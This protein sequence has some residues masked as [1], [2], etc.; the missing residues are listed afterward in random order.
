ME[1]LDA[2]LFPPPA[3]VRRTAGSLALGFAVRLEG[4]A[5]PR[6]AR[7]TLERALAVCGIRLGEGSARVRAVLDPSVPGGPEASRLRVDAAGVLLAA[8]APAG[9]FRA[10][11]VLA[12]LLRASAATRELP[13]LE[14]DDR[15]VFAERGV[16]L[17]VSRDRV[18]TME[19]LL[20][21]VELF[22][23]LGLNRLELY[24]EH[25]FAYRGHATPS[26]GA[27]IAA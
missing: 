27:S 6:A 14:I 22:A 10:A 11:H 13:C 20:E 7:E 15:P 16:M 21:L 25:T 17:D 19:T 2:I 4:D 26:S 24:T 18:P 3:T 23:S 9:L 12:R 5:L 1:P 8:P